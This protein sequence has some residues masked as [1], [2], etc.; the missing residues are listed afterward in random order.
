VRLIMLV[1]WFG[2]ALVGGERAEEFPCSPAPETELTHWGHIDVVFDF[3]DKPVKAIK[4]TVVAAYGT[5]VG[6]ALVEVYPYRKGDPLPPPR[7]EATVDRPARLC[8]CVT[9]PAGAFAFE[10]PNGRYEVRASKRDFNTTSAF[11]VVDV[12]K[13]K[14]RDLK[15]H[16]E[17]GT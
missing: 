6:G 17:V 11:V 16:L 15:I 2:V 4:G 5:A 9:S 7:D 10:V 3:Q 13:G 14:R 12:R 1:A 8:A